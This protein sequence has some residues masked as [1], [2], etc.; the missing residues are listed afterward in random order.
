[1]THYNENP[2][3]VRVDYYKPGGKWY[4]TEAHDMSEFYDERD[5]YE[6]VRKTLIRDGRYLTHFTIVVAQPYH[7]NA[8][9]IMLVADDVQAGLAAVGS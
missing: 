1:M 3:M 5:I 4:M 2:G 8:Y 7:K 9:P 6:A